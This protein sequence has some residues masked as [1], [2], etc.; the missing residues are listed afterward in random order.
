MSLITQIVGVTSSSY[1]GKIS[2]PLA[3]T[4]EDTLVGCVGRILP[5]RT[6]LEP[7]LL[8]AFRDTARAAGREVRHRDARLGPW[9]NWN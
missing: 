8:S 7:S 2:S 3:L 1:P 9:W 5:A 4:A 6:T